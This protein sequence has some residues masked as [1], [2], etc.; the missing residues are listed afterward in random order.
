MRRNMNKRSPA[1]G[2]CMAGLLITASAGAC[3]A[4]DWVED[5]HS[6]PTTPNGIQYSEEMPPSAPSREAPS[7]LPAQ[8]GYLTGEA[9]RTSMG[10][11]PGIMPGP[12]TQFMRGS[13]EQAGDVDRFMLNTR[14]DTVVPPTSLQAWL[15]RT[16]PEFNLSAQNNPDAVVEV[17]GAWDNSSQILKAMGI[18]YHEIKA[19]ELRDFPLD[20]ARVI[21]I[22]CEGKVPGDCVEPLR[23]WVIRG[24]YLISTDWTLGNFV[25]RAFPGMIGWDGYHT[26]GVTVDAMVL[27]SDPALLAGTQVTRA[28]W[29]LDE[30]S[31]AVRVLRPGT[32]RVLAR[33]YRLAGS[34]P[35]SS[36]S[37]DPRNQGVLACE[38]NYG[39]G[40][41]LHLVGHFD[42]NA[43]LGGFLRYILPDAIP[44]AGIGLRQIIATNFLIQALEAP[45]RRSGRP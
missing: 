43:P 36:R 30:E 16:H 9:S 1:A 44:G 42:Y 45:D 6:A 23:Q 24:G 15:Q 29:K 20:S 32:V 19:K 4:S 35:N 14:N 28:T 34:D 25:E 39:R 38:F 2:L 31:Q 11:S 12:P 18:R 10:L 7:H 21:I 5:R 22:N 8:G 13:T 17:K 41:V 26:K 40:A 27:P 33:S 37:I 3:L